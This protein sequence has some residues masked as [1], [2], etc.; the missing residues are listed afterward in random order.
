MVICPS[1]FLIMVIT[2]G[3]PACVVEEAAGVR[4]LLRSAPVVR[5]PV[6]VRR[7]DRVP[8]M[9]QRRPFDA[10]LYTAKP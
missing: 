1:F 3:A 6:K 7:D 2:A 8:V 10:P 9:P 4:P 5:A